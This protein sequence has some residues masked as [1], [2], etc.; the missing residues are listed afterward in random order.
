MSCPCDQIEFPP[1]L[2]IPAGLTRLPRQIAT[3]PEFR[4]ALLRDIGNYSALADWRGR[5]PDDFGVMLLEMWA[6][7]C[8]VTSFYDEVLAHENYVRTARQRA[9][10]RKLIGLLGYVPRPSVAASV[11]LAAFADGRKALT[12][13]LGAA[14][15]SGAFDG[16]PPQVF[17]LSAET[18]IHPLSNEWKLLPVRPTTFGATA[19]WMTTFLCQPGTVSVKEG[20]LVMVK[21]GAVRNA[22]LVSTLADHTGADGQPYV[23]ITLSN[24]VLIPADTPVA[25]VKLLKAGVTASV[26]TR[27]STSS[28]VLSTTD[29][30]RMPYATWFYLSSPSTSFRTDQDVVVSQLGQHW[31]G[32]VDK[33]STVSV[34]LVAARTIQVTSGTGSTVTA[35][36]PVPAIEEM[37]TYLVVE[38]DMLE[39]L[40][41]TIVAAEVTISHMSVSAGR[42]TV[43]GLTTLQ[44]TD[45]LKIKTPV[46]HPVDAGEPSRFQ[47]E[48]KNENGVTVGGALI[49]P[50]G[51]LQLD[52]GTAWTTDGLVTPVR[53]FGNIV[54]ATRGE[55]VNAERLGT[56]DSAEVNQ[57][58]TLKKSPL[59]YLPSPTTS[60]ASG[61]ASTLSVYV[62]GVLWTEVAS[63]YGQS[64]DAEVYLVRQNDDE[65]SNVIFGDG[66]R[67]CRLPT[68][69][70]VVAYYRFG[71]GSAMP[72]AGSIKQLAKPIKDLRGIRNPVAAAG[73]ADAE[74]ASELKKYAPRSA[75][76]LGRAVS[77]LDLEAAAALV[78]GVRAARA[79]WRWNQLRLRPGAQ[80]YYIGDS[81]LDSTITQRLR[82]LSEEDLPIDVVPATPLP[83]TL[84][85]QIEIDPRYLEADVVAAVRTAL[86]D[87]ETGLLAAERVGIGLALFRSRIYEFVLRTPGAS[88]V[89]SLLLDDVEFGEWAVSPGAGNYFDFENGTLLLNGT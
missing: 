61:V 29:G 14:F 55:S 12:L 50:T 22:R 83:K 52:Q 30:T 79:E 21:V 77:L 86:M 56:G 82:G 71:G 7:V 10:L 85:I 41:L 8:D 66:A 49:Y 65:E 74:P 58:F 39:M 72:P 6:Y 40:G 19:E 17:E 15:R 84:T 48:D 23:A 25:S 73:G 75:L 26:W 47:F 20:D 36:I 51:V 87:T 5:Q 54:T 44:P 35:N 31:D 1:R 28:G 53:A 62:D 64:S 18:V 24:Q 43:E 33:V 70:S 27:T 68:G 45:P 63:F 67:G 69:A 11:D 89:T 59:T 42:I 4:A 60:N 46:E 80:I 13:P 57:T 2:Y 3:F 34:Q 38:P 76:L 32:R 37:T 9:S 16:N 88:S 78:G 81:G